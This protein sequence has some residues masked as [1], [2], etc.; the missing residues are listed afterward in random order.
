MTTRL[1]RNEVIQRCYT[2]ITVSPRRPHRTFKQQQWVPESS[3]DWFIRIDAL[4]A[5]SITFH[6]HRSVLGSLFGWFVGIDALSVLPITLKI[7]YICWYKC[8]HFYA[9]AYTTVGFLP[10]NRGKKKHYLLSLLLN[11]TLLL[12]DINI[13]INKSEF[14]CI[15]G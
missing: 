9:L 4:Y 13:I 3:G 12:Q 11:K 2:G 5:R 1:Y 14:L 15:L 8:A 6:S 10:P 7:L